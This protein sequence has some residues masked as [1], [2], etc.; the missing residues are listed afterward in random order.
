MHVK[1]K[2]AT[3]LSVVACVFLVTLTV[4]N[5]KA[6]SHVH[7]TSAVIFFVLYLV[8]MAFVCAFLSAAVDQHARSVNLITRASLRLKQGIAAANFTSL[9]LLGIFSSLGWSAHANKIALC[10]WAAVLLILAFNFSFFHE[11]SGTSVAVIQDLPSVPDPSADHP[12]G[13]Y[14]PLAAYAESDEF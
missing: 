11:F 5:E 3:A 13:A 1:N 4:C 9:A 7:D 14:A 12:R 2:A 8:Y 10:E 6:C